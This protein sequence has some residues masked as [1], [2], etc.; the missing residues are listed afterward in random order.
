MLSI[1]LLLGLPSGLFPSGYPS[2]NLY[3]VLFCPIRAT[4]P[5]H[6]ILLDLIIVIMIGEMYKSCSFALCSF[7]HPPVTSSLFCRNILQSTLFSNVCY[8]EYRNNKRKTVLCF[9]S[10]EVRVDLDV[11]DDVIDNNNNIEPRLSLS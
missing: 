8:N 5:A 10:Y 1:H 11:G 7:L 3:A 2:N 6:L 4:C 9:A